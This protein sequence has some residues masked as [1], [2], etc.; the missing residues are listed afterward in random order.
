MYS[1]I[2]DYEAVVIHA[3]IGTIA[4]LVFSIQSLQCSRVFMGL[5]ATLQDDADSSTKNK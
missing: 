4:P 1:C 2:L 3:F 5:R